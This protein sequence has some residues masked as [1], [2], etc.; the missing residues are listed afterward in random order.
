MLRSNDEDRLADFGQTRA[1]I[2]ITHNAARSA[3]SRIGVCPA[4]SM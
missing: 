1:K 4:F 2:E 3:A